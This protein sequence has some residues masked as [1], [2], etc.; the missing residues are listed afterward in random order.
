MAMGNIASTERTEF[1]AR[2]APL[3]F[4]YQGRLSSREFDFKA[5]QKVG[6]W[7]LLGFV[8]SSLASKTSS[9]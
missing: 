4:A 8:L 2:V 6:F 9:F 3:A 7:P 1:E 5:A